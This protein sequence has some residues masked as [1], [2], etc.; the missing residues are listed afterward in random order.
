M[1]SFN[2]VIL[3]GNLTRDPQTKYLPSQMQVTE[4][5]LAMNRRFKTQAGEDRDEVT[6]VDCSA[7]GK[8]AELI[9]QHFTKGSPIHFEGRLK[10]DSWDDKNGGGKRSKLT[11]VVENFQ[12]VG[13]KSD[14]GGCG[15]QSSQQQHQR[16][17]AR[18]QQPADEGP[19]QFTEDDIP[20]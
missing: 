17:P 4:F 13:S 10:S 11:V 7:F 20:F 8:T 9:G 18:Q 19:K 1:S 16:P 6:F 2:K 12:F 3:M 14:G 5:G 15:E